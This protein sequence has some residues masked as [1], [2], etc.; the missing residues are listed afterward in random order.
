MVSLGNSEIKNPDF[1]FIKVK[2]VLWKLLFIMSMS[3]EKNII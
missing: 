1:G 2:K 3:T